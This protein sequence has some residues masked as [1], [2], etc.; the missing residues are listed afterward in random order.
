MPRPNKQRRAALK[1]EA[2]KRVQREGNTNSAKFSF[3]SLDAYPSDSNN[4]NDSSDVATSTDMESIGKI[5][6]RS[7]EQ[8]REL[9]RE[10]LEEEEVEELRSERAPVK[11]VFPLFSTQKPQTG[12]IECA[13]GPQADTPSAPPVIDLTNLPSSPEK[14]TEAKRPSPRSR[15]RHHQLQ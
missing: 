12:T 13:G 6:T 7:K 1:R 15:R 5:G 2:N 3:E 9:N 8:P 14:P 11:E 10:E 4:N